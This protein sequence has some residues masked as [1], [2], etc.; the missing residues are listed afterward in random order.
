MPVSTALRM[1]ATDALT[2]RASPLASMVEPMAAIPTISAGDRP[3]M[4]PR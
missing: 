3:A 1:S 4:A 2:N